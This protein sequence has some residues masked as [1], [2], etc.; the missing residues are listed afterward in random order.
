MAALICAFKTC[1]D[2]RSI[3]CIYCS[4]ECVIKLQSSSWF[5]LIYRSDFTNEFSGTPLV[6][7]VFSTLDK[8]FVYLSV[9]NP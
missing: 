7:S 6:Q 2:F 8:I 3:G 4:C 1:I 5:I 9:E